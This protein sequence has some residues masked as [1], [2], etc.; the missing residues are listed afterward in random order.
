M[1]CSDR[2]EREESIKYMEN[3]FLASG[4]E[5]SELQTCKEKALRLNRD[6]ILANHRNGVPTRNDENLITCV[7]NHDPSMVKTLRK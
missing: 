5:A 2:A 4:Y 6:E 7:I 1:I 3:K